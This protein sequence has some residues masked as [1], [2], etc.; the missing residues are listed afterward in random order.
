MKKML[1]TGAGGFIGSHLVE[2][3]LADGWEV[4]A[5]IRSSS[6]RQWLTDVRIHCIDLRYEDYQRLT[7]QLLQHAQ[8]HDKWEVIINCMGVTKTPH[9]EDFMRVNFG[10]IQHLIEAL[11]QCQMMPRQLVQL[12]SLS[13]WGPVHEQEML[14]IKLTDVPRPNTEYGRSKAAASLWLKEQADVPYLIFYPTGVY[15]PRERDYY[16]MF[17]AV[18]MHLDFV[19]GLRPQR[20][21]FV[22]VTD[23]VECIFRAIDRGLTRREYI[24]AEGDFEHNDSEMARCYAS[25]DFRRLIQREFGIGHC[26]ALHVP[27]WLLRLVSLAAEALAKCQKRASTLNGDKYHIMAQRNWMADI[28]ALRSDLGYWPTTSL[29]EGVHKTFLWYRENHWL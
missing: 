21:T 20:L 27:L 16:Q 9:R 26:L 24:V 1:I 8:E 17:K 28:S 14:P 2:R 7:E 6:S 12:S 11:R 3:A 13:A 15:G 23:L 25:S 18:R 19:P 10:Y 5:G 4:W 29:K 22:Y